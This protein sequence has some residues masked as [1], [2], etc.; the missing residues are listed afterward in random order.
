MAGGAASGR[1]TPGVLPGGPRRVGSAH[2]R[3]VS[4]LDTSRLGGW[5]DLPFF[6][7]DLPAVE[8]AIARDPRPIAPAPGH[9]FAALELAQPEDVRVVILG[10]DPYPTPGHAHGLA[11]SVEPDVR[12]LPRSLANMLRELEGDRGVARSSGD[13]RDWARQGVLMLN[14][15]LTVPLGVADGHR[16]IGWHRLTDQVLARASARPTAF[17]LWGKR[18]QDAVARTVP[19]GKHLM[20]RSAHPSPLSARKGFFGSRPFG[21]VD[22]WLLAR[23]EAPID[24]AGPEAPVAAGRVA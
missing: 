11:F 9:V 3:D 21:R 5:A 10:Q 18:A 14:T 6:A 20:I 19:D 24:W 7:L 22:A 12:P 17:I 2:G 1:R 8:D 4:G 16:R 23:G 13:L 15:A